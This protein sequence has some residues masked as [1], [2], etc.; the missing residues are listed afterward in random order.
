MKAIIDTSVLLTLYSL[1][2]LDK[3][4]L[5][6]SEVRIPREVEKEFLDLKD[7]ELEQTQRVNYI[8]NFY[9]LNKSW[10]I[11]CNEYS[12]DFVLIWYTKLYNCLN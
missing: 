11:R 8:L 7:D 5:F 4:N 12:S 6:Y 10:F 2:L 3:L 1:G 9:E